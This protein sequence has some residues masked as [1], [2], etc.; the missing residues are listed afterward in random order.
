MTTILYNIFGP[1]EE[2]S[3]FKTQETKINTKLL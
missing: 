3:I 2:F 1:P